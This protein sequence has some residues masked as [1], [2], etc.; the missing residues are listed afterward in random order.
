MTHNQKIVILTR[1][2]R[3]HL[4]IANIEARYGDS[5]DFYDLPVWSIEAALQEAFEEGMQAAAQAPRGR[6]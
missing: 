3:H 6:A 2:A 4:A 1:I 5:L